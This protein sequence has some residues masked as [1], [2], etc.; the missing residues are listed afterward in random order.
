MTSCRLSARSSAKGTTSHRRSR[1]ARLSAKP[2]DLLAAFRNSY[3]PRIV[4][5]VD[6]IATGTDI[7]PL[8]CVFFMRATKSRTFF[9]QMKGR[10]VRVINDV[11]PKSRDARRHIEDSLRDRRCDRGH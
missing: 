3:N 8:E 11:A 9:E 1:T 6:M 5:T 4:V 10:G 2:E 7:K